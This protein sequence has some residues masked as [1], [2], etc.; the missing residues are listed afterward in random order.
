MRPI[1]W[2]GGGRLLSSWTMLRCPAHQEG[3]VE[4]ACRRIVHVKV[5]RKVG[6]NPYWTIVKKKK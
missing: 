1:L 6:F 3:C 2:A 4:Q 5:N